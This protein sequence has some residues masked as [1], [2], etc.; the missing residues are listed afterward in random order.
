MVVFRL[1]FPEFS[2]AAPPAPPL[3]GAQPGQD[4]GSSSR[5]FVLLARRV[6]LWP[7][8]GA[9]ILTPHRGG[10]DNN[11][12][13]GVIL[14][15]PDQEAQELCCLTALAQKCF[16]KKKMQGAKILFL[17]QATQHAFGWNPALGLQTTCR[18]SRE[19]GN[20]WAVKRETLAQ[21]FLQPR[22]C[23]DSR[24]REEQ[25]LGPSSTQDVCTE[26]P[27]LEAHTGSRAQ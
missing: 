12:T 21:E 24:E 15:V 22:G 20:I 14:S 16:A 13:L 18:R 5:L 25:L 23:H 11:K 27:G 6:Q 17:S 19:T 8:L 26:S 3:Q 10:G 4:T 7:G 9:D 2:P 1:H